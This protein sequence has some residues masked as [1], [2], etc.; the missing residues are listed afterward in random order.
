M[1]NNQTIAILITIFLI[2]NFSGCTQLEDLFGLGDPVLRRAEPYINKII[3]ED[4]NI[5]DYALSI[6]KNCS[7]NNKECQITAIYR[8]IV[9]NYEYVSDP[10]DKELIRT[11]FETI[12]LKGG[13]CEDL[14]ILLNSLLESIGIK[15]FLVLT[16]SHAYSLAYDV[17]I[18]NLWNYVEQSLISQVEKDSGDKI[19]AYYNDTFNIDRFH[20]EFII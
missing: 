13:D 20:N 15:T 1:K 7:T 4:E 16:D 17:D 5:T 10:G 18:N 14:S 2:I 19:W 9:E 12:N 11:P 8:H 6:I 3:Y